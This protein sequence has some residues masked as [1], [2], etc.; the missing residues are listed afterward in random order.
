MD[1]SVL[2]QL[3]YHREY[4]KRHQINEYK[5]SRC[6]MVSI[7]VMRL[8]GSKTSILSTRSMA[9]GATCG[10][11][12][13]NGCF[14]NLGSSMTQRRALS[15]L[16][17]PISDSSGD[18]NS[19]NNRHKDTYQPPNNS[20]QMA[21]LKS[22]MDLTW[23][24]SLNCS[25]QSLPGNRGSLWIISMNMQ[26]TD[27]ISIAAVYSEQLRSS[28]GA[29]Y[30]RVTTYSVMKSVSEVVLASPKSQILRSQ[31]ALRSRLLGFRSR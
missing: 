25:T 6:L 16:R 23:V 12:T 3:H 8:H 10:N 18:P 11:R 29:R 21:Y 5:I 4:K 13:E 20:V 27:Q 17:N 26:P 24:I 2:H 22:M 9:A 7:P 15:L 28:S 31:F 14:G 19:C 1:D 30:Q